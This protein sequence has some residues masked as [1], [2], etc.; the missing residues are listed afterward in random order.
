MAMELEVII[1]CAT[2]ST[3]VCRS[4]RIDEARENCPVVLRPDVIARDTE[5]CLS[6]ECADFSREASR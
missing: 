5:R 4:G 1:N 2:C 6:T 3:E